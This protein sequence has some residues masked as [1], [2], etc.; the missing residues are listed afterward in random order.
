MLSIWQIYIIVNDKCQRTGDDRQSQCVVP[1]RMAG[2]KALDEACYHEQ[3]YGADDN[4]Q[5]TA[6]TPS[7]RHRAG[8]SAG[9]EPSVA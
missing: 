9:E 6:S 5:S 3:R 7:E 2:K 4:L 8:V 1:F